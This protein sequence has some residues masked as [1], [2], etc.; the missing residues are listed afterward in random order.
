MDA[1]PLAPQFFYGGFTFDKG[2]VCPVAVQKRP[3]WSKDN[4]RYATEYIFQGKGELTFPSHMPTDHTIVAGRVAAVEAAFLQDFQ[5]WGFIIFDANG[6]PSRVHEVKNNDQYNI[7]GNRILQ[8]RWTQDAGPTEMYNARSFEFVLMARMEAA[9]Q[10]KIDGDEVLEFYGDGGS[11][12]RWSKLFTGQWVKTKI[13]DQTWQTIVQKGYVT[14][15]RPF[16]PLPQ[17]HPLLA[18]FEDTPARR[19]IKS[20]PKWQGNYLNPTNSYRCYTYTYQFLFRLPPNFAI[21]PEVF[22]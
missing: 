19:I 7:S 11:K 18:A 16:G 10:N 2:E 8:F 1:D 21:N 17:P 5:D 9:Y 6:T 15:L 12:Y 20:T 22:L 14:Y 3:L 13:V 4:R